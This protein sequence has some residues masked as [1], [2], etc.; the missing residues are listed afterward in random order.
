MLNE[1]LKFDSE[2][3]DVFPRLSDAKLELMSESLKE[4]GLIDELITWNGVLID[5]YIR[6]E[7]CQKLGIPIRYKKMEF[8][9]KDD[10]KFFKI[11]NQCAQ[12]EL[13][14][15]QKCEILYPFEGFIAERVEKQR[16]KAISIYQRNKQT[17]AELHGSLKRNE[18]SEDTGTAI[19]KYANTTPITNNNK[20][21]KNKTLNI[22]ISF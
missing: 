11:Q 2:F 20:H 22:F 19:A 17:S 8:E 7:L 5:G 6:Y 13:T 3:Q 18:S 4:N 12:R 14:V 16:R 10:A 21:K 1:D 15:F 9:S